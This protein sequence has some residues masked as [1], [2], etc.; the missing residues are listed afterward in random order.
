[1]GSR[2]DAGR[3][4]LHRED[5]ATPSLRTEPVLFCLEGPHA[6]PGVGRKTK[7]SGGMRGPG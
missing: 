6:H 4:P 7:A 2:K 3:V 1:M 5:S